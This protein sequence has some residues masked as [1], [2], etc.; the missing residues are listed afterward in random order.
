MQFI[1]LIGKTFGKWVVLKRLPTVKNHQP[2]LCVCSCGIEKEVWGAHLRSGKS[3]ACSQCCIKSGSNHKQW[4]GVG[5]ISANWWT[6]HVV[7]GYNSKRRKQIVCTISIKDGWE[8]FL[9]QQRKCALTGLLLTFPTKSGSNGGTAS[10]DRI[11]SSKGYELGNIQWVHKR[12]NLMKNKFKQEE[13]IQF[14][15]LVAKTNP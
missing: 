10:L 12:I 4:K 11:D 2:W 6:N 7:R 9:T 1:D 14:C 8:Q 5:E 13:F 3:N 15:R